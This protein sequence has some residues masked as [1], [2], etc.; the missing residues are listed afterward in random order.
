MKKLLLISS[1]IALAGC[2]MPEPPKPAETLQGGYF[3]CVSDSAMDTLVNAQVNSD[4]RMINHIV[5]TS[6]CF[7]LRDGLD[8]SVVDSGFTRATVRVW[9]EDSYY[10]LVVPVEATLEQSK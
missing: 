1:L 6:Q 7:I 10:D 9:F 8:Y 5:A 3:A 4:Q 2:D